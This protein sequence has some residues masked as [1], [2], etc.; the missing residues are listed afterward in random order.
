MTNYEW[1][2]QMDGEERQ[3]W[4]DAEHG[5]D[6]AFDAA[7]IAGVDDERDRQAVITKRETTERHN[8][9]CDMCEHENDEQIAELTDDLETAYAK[10]RILRAHISKMQNGRNG[11]HIKAEKLQ[12]QV[13]ELTAE[14]AA[15]K[16][17]RELYRDLFAEALSLADEIAKLQP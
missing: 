8:L 11:W 10:N 16:Q 15:C 1:L 3:A 13:S 7:L 17:D 4:F 9:F 12:K 5:E 6:M 14:L 2:L